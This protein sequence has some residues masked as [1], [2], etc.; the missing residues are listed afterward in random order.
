MNAQLNTIAAK[1]REKILVS[2]FWLGAILA[3]LIA[4]IRFMYFEVFDFNI[5]NLLAWGGIFMG[6]KIYLERSHRT[7]RVVTIVHALLFIGIPIR[8]YLSGGNL[9][10]NWFLYL[11]HCVFAFSV[12]GQ[13]NGYLTLLWSCLS[14]VGFGI[15]GSY[16]DFP[17]SPYFENFLNHGMALF[18]CMGITIFP[19]LF[20][21]REKDEVF[22]E[23]RQLERLE[24]KY[25]KARVS[26]ESIRQ[27]VGGSLATLENAQGDNGQAEIKLDE[28]IDELKGQNLQ[29]E[30]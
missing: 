4:L 11:F 21:Y 18:T 16:F 6:L 24:G 26:L 12:K 14:L 2:I 1:Y 30:A 27:N 22:H 19:L 28:I 13:R 29:G 3:F 7:E 5:L 10:P 20:M 9:S 25:R 8:I 17:K 15:F 23:L